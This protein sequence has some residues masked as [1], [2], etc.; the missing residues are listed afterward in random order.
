MYIYIYKLE[1]TD[2]TKKEKE[3][4]KE[5]PSKSIKHVTFTYKCLNCCKMS[6]DSLCYR[7]ET[8]N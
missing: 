3:L 8:Y 7:C 2:F 6:I 4:M 1:K 5:T